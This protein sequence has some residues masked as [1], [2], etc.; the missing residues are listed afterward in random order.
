MGLVGNLYQTRQLGLGL[1]TTYQELSPR[2]S[3]VRTGNLD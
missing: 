3:K 1:Q 2:W